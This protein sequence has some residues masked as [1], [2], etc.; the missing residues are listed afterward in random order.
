[1]SRFQKLQ[2]QTR[3][4][5]H[6]GFDRH[7]RLAVTG[8][9]GAGKTAL[10]TGLLEQLLYANE[11]QQLP[12]FKVKQQQRLNG[13]RLHTSSNWQVSRFDYEGAIDCLT[14]DVP[15]WPQSTRDVSEIRVEIKYKPHRGLAGRVLDTR[16]LTLDLIDYP[17]EWLLDLPLLKLSYDEWSQQQQRLLKAELRHQLADSWLIKVQTAANAASEDKAEQQIR[18][19]ASG[20]RTFLRQCREQKLLLLQPGRMVLPGELE[21]APALEFFPWPLSQ[22]VPDAWAK[23]L[24]EKYRYYQQ[25]VVTPFYQKYFKHFNRQVVLVDVLQ[26][27][28]NGEHHFAELQLAINELMKSFSYGNNSLLKRL[29]SPVID[30]VALVATKADS[31]APQ[32]HQKLTD[33]LRVM[34]QKQRQELQFDQIPHQVFS[35][36]GIATSQIKKLS[37]GTTVL[38]GINENR[39][40]VR[41]GAPEVPD[42]IPTAADWQQG[43]I[44]PQFYPGFTAQNSPLPHIRLDQL[45]EYVLGD[46]LK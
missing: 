5:I 45:L 28:Q 30:K 35:V 46:K 19:L 24:R 6:R 16:R 23:R 21:G 31:I 13:C 25:H 11:T 34:T 18:E 2:H 3:D 10:I 1:M 17:G 33:L 40:F 44:Y 37:N 12:Y 9:S 42:A 27:L 32:D 14:G 39:E 15:R 22:P 38:D 29:M 20:Y 41:V 36:A 26:A 4:V 43:Y 8:L 7:I